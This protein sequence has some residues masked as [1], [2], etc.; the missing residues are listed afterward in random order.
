MLV[1]WFL[2]LLYLY[3]ITISVIYNVNLTNCP[4]FKNKRTEHLILNKPSCRLKCTI[5][6]PTLATFLF[7]LFNEIIT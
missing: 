3:H 2:S 1:I 4:L 5:P 7:Y 6:I